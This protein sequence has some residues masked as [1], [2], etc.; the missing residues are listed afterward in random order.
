LVYFVLI[1]VGK[2]LKNRFIMFNMGKG[3]VEV[4]QTGGLIEGY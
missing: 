2:I 1:E 4:A 3:G